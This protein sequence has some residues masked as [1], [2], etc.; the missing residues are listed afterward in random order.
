MTA[1]TDYLLQTLMC[2]ISLSHRFLSTIA[3]AQVLQSSLNKEP[4]NGETRSSKWED[5]PFL[6]NLLAF[7]SQNYVVV[8]GHE[9]VPSSQASHQ[10]QMSISSF[11]C[12]QIPVLRMYSLDGSFLHRVG[13]FFSLCSTCG[14]G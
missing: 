3:G 6:A 9:S 12:V 13:A 1:I 8:Y 10:H 2:R 11:P 4:T 5:Y 7:T 14:L